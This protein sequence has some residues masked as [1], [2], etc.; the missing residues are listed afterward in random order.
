MQMAV[1][2][3]QAFLL[4]DLRLGL[5][6]SCSRQGTRRTKQ[7]AGKLCLP[8][9][10]PARRQQTKD[11]KVTLPAER[12]EPSGQWWA[13]DNGCCADTTAIHQGKFEMPLESERTR[14]SGGHSHARQ[15]HRRRRASSCHGNRWSCHTAM[16]HRSCNSCMH[17]KHAVSKSGAPRTGVC[18]ARGSLLQL[19][20]SRQAC[21]STCAWAPANT[22]GNDAGDHHSIA[23]VEVLHVRA[24]FSYNAHE[25]PKRQPAG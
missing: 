12:L 7:D 23:W 21:S 10:V 13:T 3:H 5:S 4:A 2:S 11:V 25:L 20:G 9:L 19:K 8:A 6:P 1:Q 22:T 17:K 18:K 15:R 14:Q 24:N 16:F